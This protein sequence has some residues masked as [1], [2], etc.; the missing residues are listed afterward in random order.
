MVSHASDAVTPMLFLHK[1]LY[2]SHNPSVLETWTLS[3]SL[4]LDGKSHARNFGECV[5]ARARD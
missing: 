1:V 5:T 2:F 3:L 4:S